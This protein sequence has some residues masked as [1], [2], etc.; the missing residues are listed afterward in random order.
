[1]FRPI[2]PAF[3]DHNTG[4]HI[5]TANLRALGCAG[6]FW[7]LGE[8]QH[9]DPSSL[10]VARADLGFGPEFLLTRLKSE[11]GDSRHDSPW[12][13]D[14]R[15]C[16]PDRIDFL[17]KHTMYGEEIPHS[18]I[19]ENIIRNGKLPSEITH[20]IPGEEASWRIGTL[21]VS[22]FKAVRINHPQFCLS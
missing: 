18:S 17:S 20:E 21:L 8:T 16:L 5:R 4:P 12:I 15:Q 13:P 14:R 7:D 6:C 22:I 2:S 9:S 10:L 3:D 11:C 19:T 1:M